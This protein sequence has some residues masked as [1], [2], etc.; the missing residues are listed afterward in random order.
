MT[1]ETRDHITAG[2]FLDLFRIWCLTIE[3]EPKNLDVLLQLTPTVEVPSVRQLWPSLLA[4]VRA[5]VSVRIQGP[6]EVCPSSPVP[7]R[8]SL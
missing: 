4:P 1:F 2:A 6:R 5:C 3:M 7:G 8:A